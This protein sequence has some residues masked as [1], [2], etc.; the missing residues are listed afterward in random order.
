MDDLSSPLITC[1]ESAVVIVLEIG[2]ETALTANSSEERCD[3]M[4]SVRTR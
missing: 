2:Y 4:M 1:R 3:E